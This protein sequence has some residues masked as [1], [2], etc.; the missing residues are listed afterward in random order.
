MAVIATAGTV[1]HRCGWVVI[2]AERT[3][4]IAQPSPK[5]TSMEPVI[6]L[7][8]APGKTTRLRTRALNA[9]ATSEPAM[10]R[11]TGADLG[12]GPAST[13]SRPWDV[14]VSTLMAVSLSQWVV[15]HCG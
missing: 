4:I 8:V 5:A 3:R 6:T 14:L 2:L 9:P 15:V 12:T 1:V 7:S 13:W 10:T 11:P